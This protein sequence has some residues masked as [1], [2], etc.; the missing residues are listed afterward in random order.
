MA[1]GDCFCM[2]FLHNGQAV[3]MMS[4]LFSRSISSFYECQQI[5]GMVHNR[6]GK[7][8]ILPENAQADGA[9]SDQ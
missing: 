7:V 9:G 4:G 2:V 8:V 1:T 6:H 3:A 5:L